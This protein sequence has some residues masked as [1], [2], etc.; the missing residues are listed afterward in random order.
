MYGP[1]VKVRVH[2]RAEAMRYT[3]APGVVDLLV[4][5]KCEGTFT[6]GLIGSSKPFNSGEV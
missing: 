2:N 4:P 1:Q 5:L 6:R 3:Y